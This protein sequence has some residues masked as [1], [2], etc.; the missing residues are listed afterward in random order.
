[1]ATP[2]FVVAP[3]HMGYQ[4]SCQ[5]CRLPYMWQ[6]NASL[7][8]VPNIW[9]MCVL[10]WASSKERCP[11]TRRCLGHTASPEQEAEEMES[12]DEGPL[13]PCFSDPEAS[14]KRCRLSRTDVSEGRRAQRLRMA[15][16]PE[17]TVARLKPSC[18]IP[19]KI[20]LCNQRGGNGINIVEGRGSLPYWEGFEKHPEKEAITKET[21]T[22]FKNN[23]LQAARTITPDVQIPRIIL[24]HPSTSD[25]DVEPPI[26]D[27]GDDRLG[28]F[29][30]GDGHSFSDVSSRTSYLA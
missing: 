29:E 18:P 10:H 13:A 16:L 5:I 7:S 8:L 20:K 28:D 23:G 17:C 2:I 9:P 19:L 25:E 21:D 4:P 26:Q 15:H 14:E 11:P 30:E 1:M 12:Q 6:Q 27:Q 3:F 24:T 22:S